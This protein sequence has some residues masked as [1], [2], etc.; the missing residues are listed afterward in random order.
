MSL[1]RFFVALSCLIGLGISLQVHGE[2]P[3]PVPGIQNLKQVTPTILCGSQPESPASFEA[4][5]RRGIKVIISVDGAQPLFEEAH[6][7]GLRYV[8]V[9]IGYGKIGPQQ[10]ADLVEAVKTAGGPV[11]MHCHHGKHRGPAAAG[12]CG[13]AAGDLTRDQGLQLL[14]E[15]GTRKDYTGLWEAIQKFEPPQVPAGK[16]VEVAAVE[17]IVA[18]MVRIENHW[19]GLEKSLQAGEAPNADA[20][21]ELLLLAEEFRELPRRHVTQDEDLKKQMQQAQEATESL[22]KAAESG[23]AAEIKTAASRVL[24]RCADCHASHR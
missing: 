1:H 7:H 20:R 3:A 11:F 23:A 18:S 21:R 9:P 17:P 24:Q 15:A 16:L 6:K 4:L 12:Y 14:S 10:R 13:M 22:L 19:S 5:A 2:D 8:H